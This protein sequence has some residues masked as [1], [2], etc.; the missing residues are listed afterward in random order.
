MGLRKSKVIKKIKMD[1]QQ[2]ALK[3]TSITQKKVTIKKAEKRSD[4]LKS[5]NSQFRKH[6]YITEKK[7]QLDKSKIESV[8]DSLNKYYHTNNDGDRKIYLVAELQK[9]PELIEAPIIQIPLKEAIHVKVAFVVHGNILEEF[10]KKYPQYN[11][12]S[13]NAYI[14]GKSFPNLDLILI[15]YSL[16]NK[17]IEKK[18]SKKI[19]PFH[20][21]KVPFDYKKHY[22]IVEYQEYINHLIGSTF[23]IMK[24]QIKQII[25]IGKVGQNGTIDNVL[26]GAIDFIAKLLTQS[27]G[28]SI[29]HL[30]LK[31]NKSIELLIY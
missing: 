29:E 15:D 13:Q 31:T 16:Y 8:I 20:P 1:M 4:A 30:Y 24:N 27:K 9:I 17:I 12:M 23:S 7:V 26:K 5:T 10:Q 25:P 18:P 21:S 2:Q 14:A 3:K 19:Y 28:N 6:Q 22:N 11:V